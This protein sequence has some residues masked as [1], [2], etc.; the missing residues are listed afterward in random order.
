MTH[1][2]SMSSSQYGL[3]KYSNENASINNKW[4]GETFKKGGY[5]YYLDSYK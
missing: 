1:L 3:S 4:K 5:E 2:V